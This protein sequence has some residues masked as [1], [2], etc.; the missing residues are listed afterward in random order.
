MVD[1]RERE[2][3]II[4]MVKDGCL[5]REAAAAYGITRPRV[6]QVLGRAAIRLMREGMATAEAADAC[7]I[8]LYRAEQ[9]AERYCGRRVQRRYIQAP[10]W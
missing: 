7:A 5:P 8:S 10:K 2:A 3:D 9:L 6:D 1:Y 4:A